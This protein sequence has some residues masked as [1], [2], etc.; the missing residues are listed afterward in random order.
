M[1][2]QSMPNFVQTAREQLGLS[3][4]KFA[5]QLGVSQMTIWRWEKTGHD[6]KQ[7]DKYAIAMLV[8]RYNKLALTADDE[9]S[10]TE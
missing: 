1:D 6:I 9:L 10:E 5:N 3:R 8:E 2:D 7:R 4:K